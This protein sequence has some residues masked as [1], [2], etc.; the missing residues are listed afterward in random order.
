MSCIEKSHDPNKKSSCEIEII[1]NRQTEA[2]KGK[3]STDKI[4]NAA[5]NLKYRAA[6][7]EER[8]PEL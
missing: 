5:Q 4:Q 6:Q 1:E 2:L 7:V 8:L 3:N